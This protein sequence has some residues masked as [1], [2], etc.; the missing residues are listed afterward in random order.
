MRIDT[1]GLSNVLG[2]RLVRVDALDWEH[3]EAAMR[4]A[5]DSIARELSK[6][7]V[8]SVAEAD[9]Q[10]SLDEILATYGEAIRQEN[11][12]AIRVDVMEIDMQPALVVTPFVKTDQYA[13]PVD[14]WYL[15][16]KASIDGAVY[17]I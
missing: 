17:G 6:H 8:L 2:N 15:R 13:W 12:E 4:N 3:A 1:Y 9:I 7:G 14:G 5:A 10:N 16:A 11:P